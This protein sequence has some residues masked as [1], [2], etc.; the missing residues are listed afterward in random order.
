[1]VRHIDGRLGYAFQPAWLLYF[2]GGGAWVSCKHKHHGR[3]A[4]NWPD[5]QHGNQLDHRWWNWMDVRATLVHV[6]EGVHVDFGSR[7]GTL[8]SPS[9]TD[10]C[11]RCSFQ[12]QSNESTVLV[13]VNYRFF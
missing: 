7:N 8:F 5:Q 1:M 13:G 9:R 2:Q 6:V 12:R 11:A 3:S 4:S 10:L